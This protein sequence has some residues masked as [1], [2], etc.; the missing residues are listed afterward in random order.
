MHVVKN[1]KFDSTF[2]PKT[3]TTIRKCTVTKTILGFTL[4]F[5]RQRSV[6][7]HAFERKWG[8]NQISLNWANLKK[9]VEN[10]GCTVFC[11][12]LWFKDVKKVKEETMKNLCMC[13][14]FSFIT[15]S[16]TI[17]TFLQ[18]SPPFPP[19]THRLIFPPGERD[20]WIF[21]HQYIQPS[22]LVLLG[23][24]DKQLLLPRPNLSPFRSSSDLP[25]TR[26]QRPLNPRSNSPCNVYQ[27]FW[28][29]TDGM[30]IILLHLQSE[31]L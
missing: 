21:P 2:S 30:S 5:R 19:K 22:F 3:L 11:T 4:S 1:A 10:V 16:S 28:Y 31:C 7:Q 15:F 18:S 20:G 25:Q 6:M 26:P 9:I 14:Y 13:T 17:F 29:S 12:Y 27:I 8:V 24:R 23:L